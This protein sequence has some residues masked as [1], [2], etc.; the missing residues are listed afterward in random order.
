MCLLSNQA[1]Q[2]NNNKKKQEK[3]ARNFSLC[4]CVQ[5]FFFVWGHCDLLEQFVYIHISFLEDH[6]LQKI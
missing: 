3:Y 2:N 6:F 4:A 1:L 5:Q